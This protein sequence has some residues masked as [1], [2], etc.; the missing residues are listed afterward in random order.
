MYNPRYYG[1]LWVGDHLRL[2][3]QRRCYSVIKT[4][5]INCIVEKHFKNLSLS[6]YKRGSGSY[7]YCSLCFALHRWA[8]IAKFSVKLIL[9]WKLSLLML[10]SLNV[11]LL[12]SSVIQLV[13]WFSRERKQCLIY[14]FPFRKS[15]PLLYVAN[16]MSA[17]I[18]Y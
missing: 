11:N 1:F 15:K 4:K 7:F 13:T 2:I 8:V 5:L 9:L 18:H 10:W 6:S 16:V 12:T 14:S 3:S 17:L